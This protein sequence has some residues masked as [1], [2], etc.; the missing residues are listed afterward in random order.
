VCV[1]ALNV[2]KEV[3]EWNSCNNKPYYYLQ[4]DFMKSYQDRVPPLLQAGV[5]YLIYAGDA[6]KS[7][8]D[9]AS[10][11]HLVIWRAKKAA[12]EW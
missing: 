11:P 10:M 7:L 5:P 9:R 6:G 1:Q 2:S 8:R 12:A 4:D 3:P